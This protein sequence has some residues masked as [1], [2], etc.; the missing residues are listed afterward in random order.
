M[1]RNIN[2]KRKLRESKEKAQAGAKQRL[3]CRI[4]GLQYLSFKLKSPLFLQKKTNSNL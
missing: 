1:K 2:T 4:S 3:T